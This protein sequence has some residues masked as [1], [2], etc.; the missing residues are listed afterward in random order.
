MRKLVYILIALGLIAAVAALAIHRRNLPPSLEGLFDEYRNRGHQTELGSPF[1]GVVL[2]A[3]AGEVTFLEAFGAADAGGENP[4]R[5]NSRFLIGAGAKPLTATLVLQQV[6]AGTL[7]LDGALSDYL[8]DFPADPG[9][10]I[11]LHHLLSHTAGL[12]GDRVEPNRLELLHEPGSRYRF[13]NYGYELLIAVL[14]STTGKSYA[15]LLDEGLVAPLGLTDT[16]VAAGE[17]LAQHTSSGLSFRRVPGPLALF[18]PSDGSYDEQPLPENDAVYSTVEDLYR[19]VRA[20]R[21][22]ELLPAE[23]TQKLFEPNLRGSGYGWFRNG[24]R[25]ITRNPEAPLVSHFGQLAG[26]TALIGLYDDGTSA[27][28]LSNVSPLDP[29]A[30]LSSTHL[31]ARGVSELDTDLKHPSLGGPGA[32]DRAG[33]VEAFENYYVELSERA[34]Y[35]I[36]PSTRTSQQVMQLLIRDEK[37]AEADEFGR[38]FLERWPPDSPD[39]LNLIGYAFLRNDR[40]AESRRYFERNIELFPEVANGHDSLG[41]L[42]EREGDLAL[43][44]KNYARAVEL[45]RKHGDRALRAYEANLES[46]EEKIASTPATP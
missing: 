1:N 15:E 16:G 32:F 19:F 36:A 44:A 43:A 9:A 42:H 14:E 4:L 6:A 11:T 2:V 10:T 20:L 8:A 46:I 28:I 38:N 29:V 18:S 13:S 30:L 23:L 22:N 27:I 26:H 37:F 25:F 41:E 39:V 12:P 17:A 45:A 3:E 21:A 5:V 24:E 35:T 34:G 7:D 33:G 40:F 31:A